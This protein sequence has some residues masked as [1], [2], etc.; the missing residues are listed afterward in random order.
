ML[1]LYTS[2]ILGYWNGDSIAELLVSKE[3]LEIHTKNSTAKWPFCV[4][5]RDPSKLFMLMPFDL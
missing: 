3:D 1:N 2:R 5:Y 4:L